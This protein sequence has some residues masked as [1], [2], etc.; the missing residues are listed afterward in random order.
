MSDE[1]VLA[2]LDAVAEREGLLLSPEGAATY[3][4]WQVA[5]ADGR[6]GP[7]DRAVLFNCGSA[8]KYPMP[9]VTDRIDLTAPLDVAALVGAAGAAP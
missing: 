2:G 7:S 1:A 8:H 5:L 3:A 4:A 9:A 6:V